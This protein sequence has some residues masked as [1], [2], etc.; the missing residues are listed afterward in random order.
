MHLVRC[1]WCRQ[2]HDLDSI[3]AFKRETFGGDF[4][5]TFREAYKGSD[6]GH[7]FDARVQ[8]RDFAS[9]GELLF[10]CPNCRAENRIQ[11]ALLKANLPVGPDFP[12]GAVTRQGDQSEFRP[13]NPPPS[14]VAIGI[15]LGLFL[16]L[17]GLALLDEKEKRG[18]GAR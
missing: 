3:G 5:R 8:P 2:P 16:G 13:D 18:G 12:L 1:G 7:Y 11:G 15:L 10:V 9:C 6:W 17:L 14:D 4:K